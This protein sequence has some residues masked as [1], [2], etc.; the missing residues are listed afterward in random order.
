MSILLF[1][2]I[3][4]YI[5][6]GGLAIIGY[7]CSQ[8]YS[9]FT[10]FSLVDIADCDLPNP[11][12][13]ESIVNISL[14]QVNEFAYAPVY[15]CKVVIK[16]SA[17]HCGHWSHVSPLK[18]GEVKYVYDLDREECFKMHRKGAF[19]VA[20][21]YV[22][23]IRVN[24]S[25]TIPLNFAGTLS[26]TGACSSGEYSDPYGHFTNAL[27]R[28][29]VTITL[30]E[31]Y[32]SVNLET[33]KIILD[34]GT[35]CVFTDQECIDAVYGHAY[36]DLVPTDVC[37]T[38]R[39]TLLY[40]GRASK[41][42]EKDNE[43]SPLYVVESDGIAFAFKDFGSISRCT[44]ELIR[45][46]HPKL[47]ILIDEHRDQF[48]ASKIISVNNLDLFSYVNS[49]FVYIEKH[50]KKQM[51]QLY[52]DVLVHQCELERKVILNALN[53]ATINPELL[54]YYLMQSPGYVSLLAG[55]V[56]YILQCMKIEVN[57][58]ETEE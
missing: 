7:D 23:N 19:F 53:L 20:N 43:R 17:E 28:G 29:Y 27:V 48:R 11:I 25:I 51:Q 24:D 49:K 4:G 15:Y 30:Q 33:N 6:E 34:S 41:I 10:S 54:A 32:N 52:Q 37:E 47:F 45:T 50:L 38:N 31:R 14:V 44:F 12:I 21:Q 36:W 40:S 5:V 16:R 58:R 9:N 2:A 39:Y 8:K 35:R 57:T 3:L 56:I 22:G 55:E 46:E 18:H 26:E 13:N 1:F 42:V